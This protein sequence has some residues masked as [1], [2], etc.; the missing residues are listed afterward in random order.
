MEETVIDPGNYRYS[1][2]GRSR[3]RRNLQF[4]GTDSRSCVGDCIGAAAYWREPAM[5]RLRLRMRRNLF[6]VVA[7]SQNPSFE[8]LATAYNLRTCLWALLMIVTE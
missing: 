5:V 3:N 7:M 1:G 6:F 2:S 4:A 8:T